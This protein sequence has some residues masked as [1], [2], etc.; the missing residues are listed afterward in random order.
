MRCALRATQVHAVVREAISRERD[1]ELVTAI[2]L[3]A[4]ETTW[5]AFP[6]NELASL[7]AMLAG[8]GAQPVLAPE[9][10]HLRH[11]LNALRQAAR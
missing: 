6:A 5:E 2:A 9:I 3:A 10:A 4:P 8:D 1:A 11:Q 7:L